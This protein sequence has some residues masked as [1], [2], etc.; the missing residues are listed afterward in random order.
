MSRKEQWF[1]TYMTASS[2]GGRFFTPSTVTLDP[3]R[4]IV[5]RA[6]HCTT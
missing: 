6:H 4:V 5:V 2:G 1:G 3:K